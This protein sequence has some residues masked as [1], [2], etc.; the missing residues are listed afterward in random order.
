MLCR[1]R[2]MIENG[3]RLEILPIFVNKRNN[4]SQLNID[5]KSVIQLEGG[6]CEQKNKKKGSLLPFVDS[7]IFPQIIAILCGKRKLMMRMRKKNENFK[8]LNN[9]FKGKKL[10]FWW[11]LPHPT[12]I[13]R[14]TKG[15]NSEDWVF[16]SWNPGIFYHSND[17]HSGDKTN[18]FVTSAE[19]AK[20][21]QNLDKFFLV[22]MS[23]W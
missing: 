10:Q 6:N 2:I 7:K 4:K 14:F 23:F 1:I 8:G 22:V 18:F 19:T 13:E 20:T 11:T 15:E 3:R 9:F 17:R 16:F 5:S 21:A 12:Q